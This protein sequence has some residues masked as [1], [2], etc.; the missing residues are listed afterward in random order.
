MDRTRATRRRF[1]R[2]GAALAGLSLAAKSVSAQSHDHGPVIPVNPEQAATHPMAYGEPSRFANVV[3]RPVSMVGHKDLHNDLEGME[4]WAPLSE[5]SGSITPSGLHYVSSHGNAPPDLDPKKHT[6]MIYGLV[7]RPLI[8]TVDELKRLPSVTR[9]HFLECNGNRP[10]P[11]PVGKTL[12]QMH[13]MLSCSQWTGV[14]LAILLKEAG[15]KAGAQWLL[16]EG[17]EPTKHASNLTMGRAMMD[18]V[19]IAY[20]QNGEP[21]RPHQGFP[22]R[23]LVPGFQAKHSVKWLKSIKVVDRPGLTY[24]E[25]EHFAR[26]ARGPIQGAYFLEQGPKSVITFPSGEQRLP[27]RGFYTITGLAWSGVGAVKR[28]EISTDD[29]KT[30]KDAVLE[31]PRHR[32]A[33][34]SF[35]FPWTWNGE[36]TVL[37][38]RCIDDKDQ[39]QPMRADMQKFWGNSQYPV[40]NSIQPWKVN[41]DGTILNAL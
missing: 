31:E 23:L 34:T 20:A 8:F 3:R 11:H 17:A 18:D 33:L 27:S 19:L 26:S 25:R 28:V 13:G 24:W 15:V 38:S 41:T 36:E 30:W 10:M 37:L 16:A 39:V 35:T 29:G 4:A 21:V 32:M 2:Q 6:L 1:L 40:D 12:D 14:P 22:L 5:L 9:N 7:D